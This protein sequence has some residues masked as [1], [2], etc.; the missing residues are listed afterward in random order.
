MKSGVRGSVL[1]VVAENI[2]LLRFCNQG[3]E[4]ICISWSGENKMYMLLR[5]GRG[6]QKSVLFAA[7]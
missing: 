6:D 2:L 1:I 5:H 7:R 4:M 3:E